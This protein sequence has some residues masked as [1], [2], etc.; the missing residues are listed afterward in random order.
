MFGRNPKRK[1]LINDGSILQV[2]EI[3]PTLQGEGFFAGQAA[4][5][6]RL[7]GCNLACSF[8]DTEF[9]SFHE[10]EL[11]SIIAKAK[12]LSRNHIRPFAVITGGEPMRQNIA[13]LCEKLIADGFTVQIETNGT[14][15][16]EL[17]KSVHIICSPK[18][19]DGKYFPL[20]PDI[21]SRANALKFIISVNQSPYDTVPDVG[22]FAR[23]DLMVYLQPMDE[24]CS[25]K[26]AANMGHTLKLVHEYR[27]NL[28]LQLHKMLDVA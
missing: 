11:N 27:C 1:P 12:E 7:G 3:F 26:N 5:F 4:V 25:Q 14:L 10:M 2:Q 16:R 13:P 24:Y 8:C 28:S 22:Q 21:L 23:P 6:I 17:P 18:A 15:F 19:V 9:E 20:R